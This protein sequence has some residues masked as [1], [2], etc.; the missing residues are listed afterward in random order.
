VPVED[1]GG[2]TLPDR[3]EQ[4]AVGGGVA[5]AANAPGVLCGHDDRALHLPFLGD[6]EVLG[7]TSARV[8]ELGERLE[9]TYDSVHAPGDETRVVTYL[10]MGTGEALRPELGHVRVPAPGASRAV[11]VGFDPG[12]VALT[13]V[14]VE[15]IGVDRSVSGAVPFDW[16]YGVAMPT[17]G[18]EVAEQVLHP[19][20]I[21]DPPPNPPLPGLGAI[22]PVHAGVT[23][24][25]DPTTA[26]AP[27]APKA[28]SG[29]AAVAEG[30]ASTTTGG[31]AVSEPGRD[32]GDADGEAS[33]N[34]DPSSHSGPSDLPSGRGAAGVVLTTGDDAGIRGRDEVSVSA[35]TREGFYLRT[36]DVHSALDTRPDERRGVLFYAAWPK[37]TPG[38]NRQTETEDDEGNG[39]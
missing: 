19:S 22:D 25:P 11:D 18:G 8:R 27:S 35:F 34:P 26:T 9:L 17:T 14:D 31:E 21:T 6:D 4:Q 13:G 12:M 3:I 5:A 15:R 30:V 29:T 24:H 16:S 7:R 10:A 37:P 1:E 23:A 33:A 28:T 2:E 36:Y 32:G 39:S 38:P 20:L